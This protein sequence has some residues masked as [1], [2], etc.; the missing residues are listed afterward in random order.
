MVFIDRFREGR[1]TPIEPPYT[2][3]SVSAFL[4]LLKQTKENRGVLDS[5]ISV[6]SDVT[7]DKE[8]PHSEQWRIVNTMKELLKDKTNQ[9]LFSRMNM[10]EPGA[11]MM[12]ALEEDEEAY[13]NEKPRYRVT[14]KHHFIIGKYIVTQALWQSV[15]G[16]NPSELKGKNRPV[17][18]VWLDCEVLQQIEEKR[19]G[20]EAYSQWWKVHC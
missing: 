15:M 1:I 20:E 11:F 6:F 14:L 7:E 3:E 18:R 8:F 2:E 4:E 17:E 19:F 9:V 12:G 5:F 13:E 16:S 10:I